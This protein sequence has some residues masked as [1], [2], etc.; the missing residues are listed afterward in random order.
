M[1]QSLPTSLAMLKRKSYGTLIGTS[2]LVWSFALSEPG[3]GTEISQMGRSWSYG[4]TTSSL[5][6]GSP[7]PGLRG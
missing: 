1:S 3:S 6:G 4:F 2:T 5:R 7:S